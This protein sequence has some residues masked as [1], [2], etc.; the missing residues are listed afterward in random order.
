MLGVIEND[1]HFYEKNSD[2]ILLHAEKA[3]LIG[4]KDV[5]GGR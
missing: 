3:V 4:D 5:F 1:V 2:S